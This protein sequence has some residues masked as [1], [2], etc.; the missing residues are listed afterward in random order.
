MRRHAHVR[1]RLPARWR[2]AAVGAAALLLVAA[3]AFPRIELPRDTFTYMV[4]FDITQSMDTEDVM[5]GGAPVSRLAFAKATLRDALTRLPCGSKVGLSI[6][7]GQT[8]LPL[9]P[10]IDVCRNFDALLA[11]L[12]GIDGSMRWTNWSRIAEGGIYSAVRVA[13]DLGRGVEVVFITDGQ[14]APPLLPSNSPEIDIAV[15]GVSGWLIGVGGD[16]PVPI[17][18]SDANGT[19]IGFWSAS[20]VIQVP[21]A[22]RASPTAESHEE[23]SALQGEYLSQLAARIG[24]AYRRLSGADSLGAALQDARFA[25]RERVPT[26]VRGLPAS[27]ALVL[28]VWRYLGS[29]RWRR[30]RSRRSEI[31]ENFPGGSIVKHARDGLP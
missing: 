2:D 8:T 21:P 29:L 15:P 11:S 23:L 7:T 25:H 24:F 20:D 12:E 6:F 31:R 28:L 1:K 16:Q 10:P 22:A 18:K 13:R 17:P 3:L 19:R 30:G 5:S 4:T 14:E 27:L 9:L 26:D